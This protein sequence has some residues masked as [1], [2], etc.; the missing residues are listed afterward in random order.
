[1]IEFAY[2]NFR[3]GGGAGVRSIL[4]FLFLTPCRAKKLQKKIGYDS[5]NFINVTIL[6]LLK[7]CP[8]KSFSFNLILYF[9]MPSLHISSKH[10]YFFYF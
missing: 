3:A 4:P 1:M 6:I 2:L 7:H 8:D 9:I 5:N 10:K